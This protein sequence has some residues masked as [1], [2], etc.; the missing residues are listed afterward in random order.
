[1][2]GPWGRYVR[3]A[4]VTPGWFW[5]DSVHANERGCQIIG[6]LLELWFRSSE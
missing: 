6:R 4:G 5:G 2:T 1:M 3:D